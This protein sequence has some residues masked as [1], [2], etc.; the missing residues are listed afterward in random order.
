MPQSSKSSFPV[1]FIIVTR[2]DVQA[3]TATLI[4][5]RQ[6]AIPASDIIVVDSVDHPSHAG[7]Q[8]ICATHGV[9]CVP[10]QWNGQYPKK[11]QW[12]LE[13]LSTPTDWWLFLDADE[14]IT[15]TLI[16][17]IQHLDLTKPRAFMLFNQPIWRGQPL[18][19]GRWHQKISL[20][21]RDA[22]R[23]PEINDLDARGMGE[24]E[25]HYQ[26]TVTQGTL[27]AIPHQQGYI[28]HHITDQ[29]DTSLQKWRA[30]HRDY[31][32]WQAYVE[33]TNGLR[34]S[35]HTENS[36]LRRWMKKLFHARIFQQLRPLVVFVDS[37][38]LKAGLLDGRTGLSYA[39]HRAW[40]YS[41]RPLI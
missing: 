11:R 17:T 1:T 21:H 5:L 36:R 10:Y 26:P 6:A 37:V 24:I 35:D 41:Q 9:T 30:K 27:K 28:I 39:W 12:C 40:Y 16:K 14:R 7:T 20:F 3:L 25:G 15:P 34:T 33:K 22:I 29:S 4:H 18:R 19:F 38:V 2:D 23:F 13:N 31:A 32:H 8:K